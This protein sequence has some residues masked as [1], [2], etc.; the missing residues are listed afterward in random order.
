MVL[1]KAR[2]SSF[3][4]ELLQC[5]VAYGCYRERLVSLTKKGMDGA[6]QIG[7]MM[8]EFRDNPPRTLDGSP[9]IR[10]D[11]YQNGTSKDPATGAVSK[12]DLPNS[13]VLIYTTADGTRLAARPS[14]TEPKIK[15]YVS[16]CGSISSAKDYEGEKQGLESKIDRVLEDLK[17]EE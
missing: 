11:D 6:T 5:Y 9:V 1:A 10:I 12:I 4:R 7:N 15:F 14:G 2:G 8:K 3:Y 16:V 13:N 17:L